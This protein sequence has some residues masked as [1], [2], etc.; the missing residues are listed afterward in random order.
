[1]APSNT[2]AMNGIGPAGVTALAASPYLAGLSSLDLSWN[3][4][5]DPGAFALADS[6]YL[7]K[8]TWLRALGCQFGPQGLAA[9][10]ARFGSALTVSP[11]P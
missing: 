11:A 1:M 6:P 7:K 3:V 10:Q 2:L 8:L 9:L 4:L 5:H